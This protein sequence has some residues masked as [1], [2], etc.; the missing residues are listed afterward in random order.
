MNRSG[1]S[2][3]LKSLWEMSWISTSSSRPE[4]DLSVFDLALSSDLS[5]TVWYL[6][7]VSPLV[8]C[9]LLYDQLFKNAFHAQINVIW[10]LIWWRFENEV[11]F[12]LIGRVVFK[13]FSPRRRRRR[14]APPAGCSRYWRCSGGAAPLRSA[15]TPG[16]TG[17]WLSS[18][19]MSQNRDRLL[20]IWCCDVRTHR[21]EKTKPLW[22][23]SVNRNMNF[24]CTF[25]SRYQTPTTLLMSRHTRFL[26]SNS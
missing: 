23:L 6:C 3:V 11:I 24:Y 12:T 10:N 5:P 7:S 18:A 14:T 17:Y 22:C 9:L 2:H 19:V 21:Q 8:S 25:L 1:D 16:Q 20:A 4:P 26:V 15:Q 13:M